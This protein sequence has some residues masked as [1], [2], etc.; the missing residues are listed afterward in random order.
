MS[1]WFKR[2]SVEKE[3]PSKLE[4]LSCYSNILESEI[5]SLN[6]IQ[7]DIE[8][9]ECRIHNIQTK[10]YPMIAYFICAFADAV[11]SSPLRYARSFNR[12]GLDRGTI[13]QIMEMLCAYLES[14]ELRN[15][16]EGVEQFF[17]EFKELCEREQ[18]ADLRERES[19]IKQFLGIK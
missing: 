9:L 13:E 16:V 17:A 19:K 6:A 18:L 5:R 3:E 4:T 1:V 8:E 12:T 2:K 7:R 10:F 11:D 14:E 15:R